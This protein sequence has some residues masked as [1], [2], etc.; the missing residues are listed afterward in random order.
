MALKV[1]NAGMQP[2]GQFDAWDTTVGSS[3]VK[4]GEVVSFTYPSLA[5]NDARAADVNDGYLGVSTKKRPMLTT[6]LQPSMRPLMLCD[7]GVTGYGTLFGQVVGASVGQ[8]ST[9][10]TVLGPHTGS[11]SGKLTVW[12][13]DGLYAV[14]LDACDTN[15]STGLQPTNTSLGG[16]DPLYATTAGLL[17]PNAGAAFESVLIGH[18]IEFSTEG[19]LVTTPQSLVAAV[20]SPVGNV[21]SAKQNAFTRAVFSF[22]PGL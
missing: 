9:G 21:T 12:D 15:A 7:D 22:R 5:S 1:L 2:L 10:G 18:F 6:T 11:G 20:N 14:T 16:S 4:G 19:S 13:K 8:V 17:T 3:G